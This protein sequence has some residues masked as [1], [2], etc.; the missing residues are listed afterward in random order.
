V[1]PHTFQTFLAV[2]STTCY[3]FSDLNNRSESL[4]SRTDQPFG[5]RD[6]RS[7]HPM[8]MTS[9]FGNCTWVL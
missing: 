9:S 1:A 7:N 5:P 4:K 8:F 3:D 2:A 6:V